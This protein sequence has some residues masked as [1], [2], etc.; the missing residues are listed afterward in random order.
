[1]V[2]CIWVTYSN[3]CP[4]QF[5]CDYFGYTFIFADAK[6]KD[7]KTRLSSE[8]GR[9]ARVNLPNSRASRP[10]SFAVEAVASGLYRAGDVANGN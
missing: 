8:R 9:L 7:S 5:P 6:S 3:A 4:L 2:C 10:R 1:M